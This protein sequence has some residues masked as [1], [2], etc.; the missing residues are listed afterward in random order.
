MAVAEAEGIVA[1]ADSVDVG[2]GTIG[3]M[4]TIGE[5]TRATGLVGV[6]AGTPAQ[7]ARANNAID[8]TSRGQEQSKLGRNRHRRPRLCGGISSLYH[9]GAGLG[10]SRWPRKL[11]CDP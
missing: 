11:T 9:M 2:V 10:K 6:L 5:I 4:V 1:G 7:A 3:S 8:A